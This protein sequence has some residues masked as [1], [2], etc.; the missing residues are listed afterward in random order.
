[1]HAGRDEGDD[2]LGQR[3]AEAAHQRVGSRQILP[4]QEEEAGDLLAEPG[5]E[6]DEQDVGRRP[7][8]SS[9]KQDDDDPAAPHGFDGPRR[10]VG[11]APSKKSG[12]CC[13]LLGVEPKSRPDRPGRLAS[14]LRL[15]DREDQVGPQNP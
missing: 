1:M 4:T 5:G 13:G 11:Q 2:P 7:Y 15:D 3:E 10:H 9:M 12:A 6:K 8:H 14:R